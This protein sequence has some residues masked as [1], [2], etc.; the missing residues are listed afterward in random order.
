[1]LQSVDWLRAQHQTICF[2]TPSIAG[3][4]P[5]PRATQPQL[6][7]CAFKVNTPIKALIDRLGSR[8]TCPRNAHFIVWDRALR[9]GL[10]GLYWFRLFVEKLGVTPEK[11]LT[12]AALQLKAR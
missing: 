5:L 11:I 4:A 3:I 1:M 6:P 8:R 10:L 9:E 7:N 12:Y 2:S